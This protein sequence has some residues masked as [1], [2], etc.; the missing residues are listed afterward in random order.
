MKI[1][2]KNCGKEIVIPDE[3]VKDVTKFVVTCPKCSA[4][5]LVDKTKISNQLEQSLLPETEIKVEYEP[6]N[7]PLGQKAAFLFLFDPNLSTEVKEFLEKHNY[8]VRDV[9][10]VKEGLARFELNNYELVL[11]EE[12]KESLI[13][14]KEINQWQ[15]L[16][17]R[18]TN[19]IVLGDKYKDFDQK[20]AFLWG[21]NFYLNKKSGNLSEKLEQCFFKYE[22][23]LEHWKI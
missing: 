11:L 7:I 5:T 1:E 2:C 6:D 10:D 8:F 20:S 17:R 4:R 21:V 12:S 18:N 19:V 15:L 22:K 13:L 3:K 23:Y 16:K 9:Q 14:I